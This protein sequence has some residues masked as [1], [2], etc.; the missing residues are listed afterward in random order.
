MEGKDYFYENQYGFRDKH[1]VQ[2]A[3]VKTTKY[4]NKALNTWDFVVGVFLDI[5]KA[6]DT[7]N[8]DILYTKL[9]NAGI[10]GRALDL[11]ISYFQGRSQKVSVN[12]VLS[13]NKKKLK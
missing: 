6:F 9:A 5:S 4:I 13:T 1:N 8:R 10:R 11:L 12:G 3:V 2:Q 7:I